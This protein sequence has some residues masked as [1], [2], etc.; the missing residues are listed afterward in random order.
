MAVA[1]QRLIRQLGYEFQDAA[2]VEQALTHRSVGARN[3]ERLEFLGDSI[4]GF[5]IGEALFEKFPQAREGDLSRMRAQL[6]KGKTLAE[7][8]REFELG[9]H[10]ILGPGEMK[11]GGHRRE[12]ILADVVEALIGA[13][14][15]EAGMDVCRQQVLRW[16]ASRLDAV[17]PQANIKDAKT[18]LQEWLQARKQPLPSYELV[19]TEGA[20]HNQQ[21]RVECHLSKQQ[22]RFQGLASSRKAAEQQGAQQALEYLQ[23]QS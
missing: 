16:Y 8:A 22:K 4:L 5:L 21:F 6:V 7:I 20:E 2:L 1:I 11:S 15:L 18:Q 13:I 19:A 9:D 14:Y 3:N 17:S 10:L 23:R 12:S